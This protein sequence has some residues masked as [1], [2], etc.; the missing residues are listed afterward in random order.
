MP[1]GGIIPP[2][3]RQEWLTG[4]ERGKRI[5]QLAKEA[6]R[7]PRTVKDQIARARHERDAHQVRIGLLREAYQR[8]HQD[9]IDTAEWIRKRAQTPD[10]SGLLNTEDPR[11]LRL[12]DALRAHIARWVLWKTCDE[13]SRRSRS[14]EAART[15]VGEDISSRV[16]E[17][18][19]SDNVPA[20]RD[21]FERSLWAAVERRA[22]GDDLSDLKYTV[23]GTRKVVLRWSSVQLTEGPSSR[24][25]AKK[26]EGLHSE[27]LSDIAA[28]DSELVRMIREPMVNW[29]TAKT[30]I[31]A[32]VDELQLRYMVPGTCDL[33]PDMERSGSRR[34]RSRR[35]S[36]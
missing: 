13:W 2:S 19:D 29:V 1:R 25:A 20:R 28:P 26:V 9:L 34:R 30:T 33:C 7:T 10:A 6:G 22:I 11:T 18:L 14:L 32:E 8:H 5:D 35:S 24:R 12:C 16:S 31:E 36:T 15:S 21:G 17:L 27:L 23:E 3:L 4:H